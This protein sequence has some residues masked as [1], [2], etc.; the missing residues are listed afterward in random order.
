MKFAMYLINHGA[1]CNIVDNDNVLFCACK[2]KTPFDY[3]E[4]LR[5]RIES[6]ELN[7]EKAMIQYLDRGLTYNELKSLL[8]YLPKDNQCLRSL[9]NKKMQGIM[10]VMSAQQNN[11]KEVERY[12]MKGA[13]PNF[14]DNV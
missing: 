13:D 5:P 9:V 8:E 10:L 4:S 11:L 12:L 2:H 1:L 3:D 7:N 6:L 14:I